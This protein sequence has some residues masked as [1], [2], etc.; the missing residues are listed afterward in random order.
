MPPRPLPIAG[1]L[2]PWLLLVGTLFS[3]PLLKNLEAELPDPLPGI[4]TTPLT[5]SLPTET[6]E[7]VSLSDLAGHLLVIT[8][9]PLANRS[10]IDATFAGIRHV[11][12]R[13]RGLGSMVVFVMLCHGGDAEQLSLLLDEKRAR[14]PVNVF[15]LDQG[16]ATSSWLRRQ[17]G[18]E[19]AEFFLA[20][21]HARLRGLYHNTEEA[22]DRLVSSAGQLANWIESDPAPDNPR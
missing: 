21:R 6:G 5:F 9:L 19:S 8:E 13:L 11:R 1:R 16:R 15:L 14:K 4:D 10:Q 22:V 3:L 18:S 17:A 2:W 12:K 7:Q 20:D